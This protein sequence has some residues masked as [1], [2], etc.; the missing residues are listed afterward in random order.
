[1]AREL[2]YREVGGGLLTRIVV[3]GGGTVNEAPRHRLSDVDLK[4]D[5]EEFTVS[6]IK[7][8]VYIAW[9]CHTLNEPFNSTS[10]IV[11]QRLRCIRLDGVQEDTADKYQ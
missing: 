10:L 5:V 8:A 4:E 1:M 6:K 2:K 11:R 7:R 9:I 3:S